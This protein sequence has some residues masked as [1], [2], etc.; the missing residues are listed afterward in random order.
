MELL[1]QVFARENRGMPKDSDITKYVRRVIIR[2]RDILARR[3]QEVASIIFTPMMAAEFAT[4]SGSR[5][6]LA[7]WIV[8]WRNEQN[9]G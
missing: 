4:L 1:R 3:V 7:N 9:L 8:Q 2:E 5:Q 6:V